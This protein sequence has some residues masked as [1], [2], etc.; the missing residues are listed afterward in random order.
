MMKCFLGV[1]QLYKFF[2]VDHGSSNAGAEV[3]VWLV[4][5]PTKCVFGCNFGIFTIL[6]IQKLIE[7]MIHADD[8][9]N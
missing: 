9:N 7:I 4:D 2:W 3:E 8:Y 5:D 6:N 1:L